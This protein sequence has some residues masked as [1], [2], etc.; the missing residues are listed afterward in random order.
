M[1][2]IA[3]DLNG[4][5]EVV[6]TLAIVAEMLR[7]LTIGVIDESEQHAEVVSELYSTEFPA[8][9]TMKPLGMPFV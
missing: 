3:T 8:P 2:A 6:E 9:G 1:K 4:Y 5:V 7:D